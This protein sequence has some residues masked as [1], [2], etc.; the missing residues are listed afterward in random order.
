[1]KNTYNR[2][3]RGVVIYTRVSSHD[4]K[5]NGDLA[6]QVQVLKNYCDRRGYIIEN[7]I[8]DLGSG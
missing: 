4:Q 8:A 1:M 7:I 3:K 5:K 6:R 2:K